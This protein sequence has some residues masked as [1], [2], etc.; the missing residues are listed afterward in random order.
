MIR[1]TPL[2][3][4]VLLAAC[5]HN[6]VEDSRTLADLP[7]ATLPDQDEGVKAADLA[8]IE[9]QYRTA[10]QV[11]TDPEVRHHIQVR[12][13]DLEMARSEQAQQEAR[14][15]T[16]FFAEPIAHYQ[17]L[18]E[19]YQQDPEQSV[20][21]APD[22]L[23]YK[24]AKAYALD[25]RD[26]EA[27]ATLDELARRFPESPYI[28]EAQFRRAERA[29][30]AGDYER[31]GGLYQVVAASPTSA[32]ADNALYM[33]GW[34]AYKQG[35][36]EDALAR[37]TQLL[38][39]AFA[40][41]T[42]P[43]QVETRLTRMDPNQRNLV[44]DT[45]RVISFTY[46]NLDGAQSIAEQQRAI[47]TR[48]YQHRLYQ[49]LGQLY[50]TQ[51]RYLDSADTYA[52]FVSNNPESDMAPDFS[53]REI[54]AYQAG[55]FPSLVLP[56]KEAYVDQY[57]IY[58][59]YW[60]AR[61]GIP[62]TT[63]ALA[64]RQQV[65]NN[66]PRNMSSEALAQL[67]LYLEELAR[68]NHAE[69]QRLQLALNQPAAE[70]PSRADVNRAY[71]AAAA[72]Y[73]EFIVTFPLDERAGEM[74]F[75]MAEAYQDSG[76]TIA[77]LS[78]YETVAFDRIDKDYGAEAGYSSVLLAQT[79]VERASKGE[80]LATSTL[81]DEPVQSQLWQWQE[82]KIDNALQFA[83][84]YPDDSRALA[85]LTQTAPELLQQQDYHRAATV[86]QQVIDWQPEP[87]GDSRYTAWLT[88]AHARF[89]Q[90]DYP[91]AEQAYWQALD[92]HTEYG[93]QSG[94][95]TAAEIHERI[96]AS[97]YQ[98]GQAQLAAGET[99]AG[100]DLL[101][102]IHR[103]LPATDIAATALFDAG[104]AAQMA[105]DYAQAESLLTEFN[106]SYPGHELGTRLPAKL[107]VIYEAQED[108]SQ[109]AA[110]LSEQATANSGTEL[111]RQS[112]LSAAEYYDKDGDWQGA[113]DHYRDYAHTYAEPVTDRLEV[114]LRLSELYNEVGDVQS[115]DFW[116]DRIIK[117]ARANPTERSQYLGAQAAATLAE[118]PYNRFKNIALTL[119]IKQSL[120]NKRA[121][122][123]DALAAQQR[124]LD[125]KV[126]DFTTR[127]NY[128]I[129]QI[130]T[131]LARDLMDSERPDNLN[132]LELEQYD[133]LLEEQVFPLEEKAIDLHK[134]NAERSWGG[135]YDE[136]VAASID[137]LAK[138]LP[139]RYG[140]QEQTVE[141]AREIR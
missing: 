22:A 124:V 131:S 15:L 25:G 37:F 132:A 5:S 110:L 43:S 76:R 24:L 141:V 61:A 130:Y 127:A 69:A 42:L 90:E 44:D 11:A 77:A 81:A 112:L 97:I 104:H 1:V 89:A 122:L 138:L 126:A 54:K 20:A 98:Q 120:G 4:A 137:S 6:P 83:R 29:F 13:A 105:G 109:A 8:Q 34:A 88:L 93:Q 21:T 16:A 40:G 102:R 72:R 48:P 14:T 82:R 114:E 78:A 92:L 53:I 64:A 70:A 100:I 23:Y 94:A 32:F 86:A 133:I 62:Q 27:A 51:D 45:L 67:R 73:E 9:A 74:N 84:I 30:A 59:R 125:F 79:L 58:S 12:L 60:Q 116:L 68:H 113:R 140:K 7:E 50:Q 80:P 49:Q 115:R 123:D 107:I 96:A 75:L 106:A 55:G 139:A 85:V 17:A 95:P 129:G 18:V 2:A 33:Q 36:Y 63:S 39:Q 28:H 135:I 41:A 121:A 57:G 26:Q 134:A 99:A 136:W 87:G 128:F 103:E 119:P 3:L 117:T 65:R 108:W 38:D 56:A 111:G 47:G 91:A 101:L 118:A 10:L 31:A 66:R 71:S 52:R 46:A 35:R 19:D